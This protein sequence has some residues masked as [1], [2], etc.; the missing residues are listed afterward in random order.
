MKKGQPEIEIYTL[1]YCPYCRKAKD[2]L[3]SKGYSYTEYGI[4][5]EENKNE[6]KE[7]TDGA[8]TVPQIFIDGYLVGGYDDMI[9]LKADGKLNELLGIG[10][11]ERNFNFCR[12]LVV[13]GAGPAGLN[14]S[15][16]AARKGLDVLLISEAMGGQ[17]ADTGEVDNYLG[18][19]KTRGPELLRTFWNHVANYDVDIEL[20]EIVTDVYQE[21]EG[22]MVVSC[23]TGNDVR[24]QAVISATGADNRQLG[25][26]GEKELKGEGVHYCATCDGYLYS[27]EHVAVVGGGNS[28]LEAALDM[29][30][31]ESRVDLIEVQD[32]LTGDQILRERVENN[33]LINIH[34]ATEVLEVTGES[35]VDNLVLKDSKKGSQRELDVEAVFVEIGLLPNNDYIEEKVKTNDMGEIVISDSNETSMEGLWAAGDV[36]DI[37]DKQIIVSAAEG[38]K[39]AL[40]VN[41]Y[42]N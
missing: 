17:M 7:R 3:K 29:A 5:D 8:K 38:A 14:A 13:I 23:S 11:E 30:R 2:F 1:E 39:A 34:T 22:K 9:E 6:M 28:G 37:Q 24:T 15:L 33:E 4:E 25:V 31:L 16:Y 41:E 21:E 40:R 12:D 20:G 10:E 42:L 36:T 18:I 35:K 26:P 19:S 27:G 32:Q